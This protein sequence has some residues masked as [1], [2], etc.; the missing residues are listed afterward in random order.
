[1]IKL[2]ATQTM[3]VVV[4]TVRM[5]YVELNVDN[6][7]VRAILRYGTTDDK[8]VFTETTP[9]KTVFISPDGTVD[10][11]IVDVNALAT[12]LSDARDAFESLILGDSNIVA[13]GTQITEEI[14]VVRPA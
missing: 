4:D 1:M 3:Q 7:S 8:G 10:G 6:A 11:G 13:A 14:S 5:S 9:P 2:Q 12:A